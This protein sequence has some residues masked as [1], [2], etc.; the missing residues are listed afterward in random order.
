[1]GG[2]DGNKKTFL[3]VSPEWVNKPFKGDLDEM[4]QRKI[5]RALVVYSKTDFFF[6]KGGMNGVQVEHL[7]KYEKFLN[8]GVQ[9]EEKKIR[10]VYIPVAFDNL[11]PALNSGKG[12]I[13]AAFLTITPERSKQFSFI[14][15]SKMP[16]SE[17]W[18]LINQLPI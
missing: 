8:Q 13:A 16:V 17:M 18:F 14:T 10:I 11:L 7:D 4:K 3:L 5:I 2:G 12:D 1:V 15:G 9:R 6:T